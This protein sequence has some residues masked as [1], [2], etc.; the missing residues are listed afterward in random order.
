MSLSAS[1]FSW[2]EVRGS[3]ESGGGCSDGSDIV[4]EGEVAMKRSI[5]RY[6]KTSL[7]SQRLKILQDASVAT[8]Q[9]EEQMS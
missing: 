7:S 1:L 4:I 5:K 9:R 3:I 6:S 2:G 8:K